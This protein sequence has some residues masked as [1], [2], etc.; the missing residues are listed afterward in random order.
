M[1]ECGESARDKWR[2]TLLAIA[3]SIHYVGMKDGQEERDDFEI[4]PGEEMPN[5]D[6]AENIDEAEMDGDPEEMP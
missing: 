3:E 2:P 4:G 5:V 1:L 6:E